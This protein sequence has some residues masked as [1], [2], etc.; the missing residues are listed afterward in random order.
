LTLQKA[1]I[2][3][4]KIFEFGQAYVALSRVATLDGLHILAKF[5]KERIK[6]HPQVIQFYQNLQ[7]S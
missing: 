1:D 3:L 5:S 2:G 7:K 4:D 6:A